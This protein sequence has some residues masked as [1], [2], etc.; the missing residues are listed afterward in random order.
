MFEGTCPD[1]GQ[2]YFGWALANQSERLCVKCGAKLRVY[3]DGTP[4]ETNYYPSTAVRY[5]VVSPQTE[6]TDDEYFDMLK[7]LFYTRMN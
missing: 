4:V 6:E 2:H 7:L 5:R 1:C 3:R